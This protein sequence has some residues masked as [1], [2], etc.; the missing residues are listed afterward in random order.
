[1]KPGFRWSLYLDQSIAARLVLAGV[2]SG[3]FAIAARVTNSG[4]THHLP[5]FMGIFYVATCTVQMEMDILDRLLDWTVIS[6]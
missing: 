1:M 6:Y 4:M 3:V 5:A 2:F